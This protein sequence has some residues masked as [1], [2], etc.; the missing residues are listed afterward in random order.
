M[1]YSSK[2][3]EFLEIF[4]KIYFSKIKKYG[5]DIIDWLKSNHFHKDG[6]HKTPHEESLYEHLTMSGEIAYNH[7]S[8][9]NGKPSWKY[10]L[11][12][13]LHDIGK[14]GTTVKLGKKLLTMK[15]HGIVGAAML[16]EWM[17]CEK[18][19]RDAFDLT[20]EDMEDLAAVT[21]YHM[22]G[23][24]PDQ[25]EDHQIGSF[26]ICLREEA[27]TL[28]CGL[29]MGDCMARKPFVNFDYEKQHAFE[30]AVMRDFDYSKKPLYPDMSKGVL[31]SIQ[32]YSGNG[33]T[34]LAHKIIKHLNDRYGLEA[35]KDVIY[36]NRD[37]IMLQVVARELIAK[38]GNT[39]YSED[40]P[41]VYGDNHRDIS[42]GNRVIS[43]GE[44]YAYYKANH[45]ILSWQINKIVKQ[46]IQDALVAERICIV[47]TMATLNALSRNK[48]FPTIASDCLRVFVWVH[49]DPGTFT[50]KECN[51]RRGLTRSD[52]VS[53]NRDKQDFKNPI[54]YNIPWK[55]MTSITEDRRMRNRQDDESKFRPHFTLP[56]GFN[57]DLMWNNLC[58]IFDYATSIRSPSPPPLIKD[59]LDMSLKDLIHHLINNKDI[60]I[61]GMLSFFRNHNYL[62]KFK[63]YENLH[64]LIIKYIDG[65]NNLWKPRWARE[66]RGRGYVI[67][68]DYDKEKKVIEIKK[69]LL[70]GAELLTNVH[71]SRNVNQTQDITNVTNIDHLDD[72]QK[73][74]ISKFESKKPQVLKDCYVS[75]KVDGSLLVVSVYRRGSIEYDVMTHVVNNT[76]GMW[77][78][79]TKDLLIVP[80]TSGSIRIGE[81]MKD[82]AVTC[83]CA[84]LG[85]PTPVIMKFGNV[86]D[87]WKNI[88]DTF[89]WLMERIVNGERRNYIHDRN[90]PINPVPDY[91]FYRNSSSIYPPSPVEPRDTQMI[92]LI[93]EM[94]CA[95]R[96]TITHQHHSELAVSYQKSA[97]YL[98]GMCVGE[99][100]IPH[101]HFTNQKYQCI[102]FPL[103]R[104]VYDTNDVV[105]ML[106][107]LDKVISEKLTIQSY[108][109]NWFDNFDKETFDASLAFH[110]EGFVFL[111]HRGDITTYSKIKHPLYYIAHKIDRYLN[112]PVPDILRDSYEKPLAL[113]T[114]PNIR[115]FRYIQEDFEKDTRQFLESIVRDVFIKRIEEDKDLFNVSQ[116][117]EEDRNYVLNHPTGSSI[118]EPLG[119]LCRFMLAQNKIKPQI[120]I[121]TVK[122]FQSYIDHKSKDDDIYKRVLKLLYKYKP[123]DFVDEYDKMQIS[124]DSA[125]SVNFIEIFKVYR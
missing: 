110:A 74:I 3:K 107:D 78:V 9:E 112:Q 70:R 66:A 87:I 42:F 19:F 47:D 12:G 61:E 83:I 1:D 32:G 56:I 118:T 62:V 64:T 69:G 119:R 105:E 60:G 121:F 16:D 37:A 28:L 22:C 58:R 95:N 91:E 97:L 29:R 55:V 13:F 30:N 92:S 52:Q 8:K 100:Y 80:A 117:L 35:E 45:S 106:L 23:Y 33:K 17:F 40:I 65:I 102:E 2:T 46:K 77:H 63:D 72:A 114:F 15:G 48:I 38:E 96:N 82:Y 5:S 53:I 4:N 14:P 115:K 21:N 75:Q 39:T 36:V 73:E 120:I 27:R 24:F 124:R 44:A 43:Y 98:L 67:L 34:R 51:D 11:A 71:L 68:D 10:Y 59:T 123:W 31:I 86:D 7:L 104:Q 116:Y 54:G 84:G 94:V 103:Y 57:S 122:F 108:C 85:L 50:E 111:Q 99:R 101:Y 26:S 81:E 109:E 76:D 18:A 79:F 125:E 113:S 25:M 88:K 93:F 49:R 41:I 6:Q 20:V 89:G 90:Q